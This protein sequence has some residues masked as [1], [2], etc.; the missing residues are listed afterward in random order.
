M[1][2]NT[3]HSVNNN[4]PNETCHDIFFPQFADKVKPLTDGHTLTM[5]LD[6]SFL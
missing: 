6:N 1:S 2:S 3:L 4:P 5:K